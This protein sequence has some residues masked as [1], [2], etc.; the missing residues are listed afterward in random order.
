MSNAVRTR[1][2]II[3]GLSLAAALASASPAEAAKRPVAGGWGSGVA[4]S[5][6]EQPDPTRG[7]Q[8]HDIAVSPSGLAIAA[9]DRFS[10]AGSGGSTI[11]AAVEVAGRWGSPF[12]VSGTTGFSSGPRVAV[13]TDGALAASWTYQD[14]IT[15]SAP[16][17][18]VQ[19]AVR[20]AGG[21]SWV[22]TTLATWP[23]GGVQGLD[24]RVA[25][26]FDGSGGLT[27]AWSIWNGSIHLVQ[28][29]MLPKGG[30]WSTPVTV[31]PGFDGLYPA[32][33]VNA[34]GQAGLA[35]VTSPYAAGSGTVVHYA[36]RSGPS[37]PW[38]VPIAV[39]D[40]L[41]N[42]VG[43]MT[44]PRVGLDANG[45][46][47]VAWL[48]QGVM[49]TRQ[50][51]PSAWTTPVTV[52]PSPNA[53]SSFQSLDLALD[54]SGNAVVAVAI[55]DA[56]IGVDRSSTWAATG[57]AS[58][59]WSAARRLTDPTI[60]V[61]AY[62]T[63]AASSPDGSLVLVGW[64]DHYHGTIQ[65]ARLDRATGTWATGT[66][67]KGTAFSTFQ[68]VLGLDASTATVARVSWKNASTGTRVFVADFRG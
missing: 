22:T 20:A 45:R 60:P 47:T 33:A 37:A 41:P 65:V 56:T 66:V 8:V 67:G 51:G 58:G 25:I 19:V 21:S 6:T 42:T 2:T 27:A 63:R 61:D 43:Y 36:Y 52:I 49:A 54:T 15:Q 59:G 53:V 1:L 55:F 5:G 13:S 34:A 64:I 17:E 40:T 28:A 3:L 44:A 16:H 68:E 4:V 11:G 30:D 9:W 24:R 23:I 10:Y 46:A 57:T 38:S 62:A 50:T 39:S 29:A 32:L 31:E 26:A 12:L 14:P 7:S 35:Y 48:G 18:K